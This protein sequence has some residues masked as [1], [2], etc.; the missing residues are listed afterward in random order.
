MVRE[1]VSDGGSWVVSGASAGDA[2]AGG[3][4]DPVW[5]SGFLGLVILRNQ[6]PNEWVK[7][8]RGPRD[9]RIHHCGGQPFTC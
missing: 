2:G 8:S 4:E 9:V 1:K 7:G 6:S 3:G 5:G